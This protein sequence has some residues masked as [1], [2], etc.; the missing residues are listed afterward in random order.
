MYSNTHNEHAQILKDMNEHDKTLTLT[1]MIYLSP[2]LFL[3][4]F[5]KFFKHKEWVKMTKREKVG[6]VHELG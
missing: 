5:Y 2:F 4:Y 6:R 3:Y 1:E